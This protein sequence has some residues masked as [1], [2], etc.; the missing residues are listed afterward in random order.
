MDC[1]RTFSRQ[2]SKVD[3]DHL[4]VIQDFKKIGEKLPMKLQESGLF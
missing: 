1:Q 4:M 2:T 3:T